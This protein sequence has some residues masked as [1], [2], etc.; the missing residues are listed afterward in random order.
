MQPD[1]FQSLRRALLC[2]LAAA[3][4]VGATPAP[5]AVTIGQ[6]DPA[7]SPMS[8]CAG[9]NPQDMIQPTV[10]SGTSYVVPA[11]GAITSWSHNA[12]A[13]A[14]QEIT[15]KVWRQVSG[16]TYRV[17]GHDTRTLSGPGLITFSGISV[18]AQPGD[19]LGLNS[20]TGAFV[21]CMFPA[22]GDTMLYKSPSE[23]AD[24]EQVTFITVPDRRPNISAI[25]D[26][27]NTFTLGPIRRN[28]K[29]GTATINVTVPNPG[30]LAA[31]GNGV[32]AARAV[33]SKSV[34]AGQAQLLIKAKGKKRRSL[35][36]TGKVKLRVAVTY[37]PSGGSSRTQ[38][39]KVKLKKKL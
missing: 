6:T 23:A 1:L 36:E 22:I 30:D 15:M 33:K 32:K 21:D 5:A 25:F 20:G 28:K 13:S 9:V 17:V 14:N 29:K 16:T 3:L 7:S 2:G 4:A 34:G 12:Y 11:N 19:V 26:P 31:S 24:G 37:T 18:P 27:T 8:S 38:S 10:T 39:L 35:N